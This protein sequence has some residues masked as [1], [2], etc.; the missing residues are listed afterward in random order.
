MEEINR[1]SFIRN[2]SFPPPEG[3]KQRANIKSFEEYQSLYR[4]SI[5]S[6]E[7][8]WSKI[9]DEL[10]WFSPWT[11]VLDESDPP[12]YKWFLNAKTNIAY[13][14]LDRHLEDHENK[15]AIMFE[16]ELGDTCSWTYMQV[17]QETCKFANTLLSLGLRKGDRVA[18]YMPLVPE[19]VF[20]MLACARIGA[21]H[22]VIF[23][24]FAAE[25]IRS[26]ILDSTA[27]MVITSDGGYRRGKVLH[28]KDIVDEAV[29]G[30]DCVEKVLVV[31]RSQTELLPC[32]MTEGRDFW[33]HE[34]SSNKSSSH[35]AE[36]MDSEDLL[37]M[38]YTSGTTGKP[39]G[40]VHSTAGYMIG[41]YLT[42][43]YIFDIHD[44][45]VY[46]CTAD[47]G[48]ITGHSYVVYGP[49]LNRA[50]IFIYEGAPNYPNEGRF[51][52]LI[53][54]HKVSVFYT[55]PTAIRTFMRWGDDWLTRRDLSSLRLLGSVGEPI[56]PEAWMW[57]HNV[58]GQQ[59]CPIVDTWWQTETGAI[60]ISPLPGVTT[61]KPGTATLP[62][63]GVD[64]VILTEEGEETD[65]GW[66][67]IR[68]P[69]PSML[70]GI[71]G[72]PERFK[73]G[74]FGHWEG[75]YYY[76]SDGAMKDSEGYYYII[77]RLDDIVNVSGHRIST[78]ELEGV[79]IEDPVVVE[80]AVI[81]VHHEIK[82]QG[83]VG[84][85]II[86]EGSD[87]QSL[88]QRLN[89]LVG[90]KI[91]RFSL[92]DKIVFVPELPKTRSGKIMRRLLRDI[93]EK[94]ELGNIT[95]LADPNVIEAIAKQ[96]K[97]S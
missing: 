47:I 7:T 97:D 39:K 49:M 75:K 66:L 50:T 1:D 95:T 28:L 19:A 20:A 65:Y 22:N 5:Q 42:T 82:G 37:F 4:E 51:W 34:V 79:L 52:E 69:W 23:G 67:A 33:Y 87:G 11:S 68:K 70:R 38:L 78:A 88:V 90:N 89:E 83:L 43:K 64:P 86:K 91:G 9:A 74:Y 58:V 2:V 61:C 60:M 93:A 27:K 96:F 44:E 16:G 24:G 13:N 10:H 6:P 72:N 48:W 17:F 46:W 35:E 54:K 92:L 29:H 71:Y 63:F 57:Y 53:E 31:R 77:G 40:I 8:F 18:I 84:F 45:D 55:A 26:R 59:K 80:A 76:T 3:F 62:F 94:R 21:V 36:R 25:S 41:T 85:L 32:Q 81:G 30:C 14:C 12:F 15:T 73:Q 56:N